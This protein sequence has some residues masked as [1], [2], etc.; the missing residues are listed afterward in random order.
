MTFRILAITALNL[1]AL[2]AVAA[3]PVAL[4]Q[5]EPRH[6]A[7]APQGLQPA[8]F[9]VRA[10]SGSWYLNGAAI[11]EGALMAQLR[12][13]SNQGGVRFLPSDARSSAQVSSDLAW[14]R[15]HSRQPVWIDRLPGPL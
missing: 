13:T 1:I 3:L 5:P 15:R 6:R 7:V 8:W 4:R 14:L 11:N 9:L 12:A 2:S 10:A